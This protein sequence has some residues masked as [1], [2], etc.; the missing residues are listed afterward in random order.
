MYSWRSKRKMSACNIRRCYIVNRASAFNTRIL[1][2][3]PADAFNAWEFSVETRIKSG[4]TGTISEM[5]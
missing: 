1:L 4:I 5:T 2:V 3:S